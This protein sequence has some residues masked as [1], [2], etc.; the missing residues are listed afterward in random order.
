MGVSSPSR[1][2]ERAAELGY[3]ALALT[4]ENGVYGVVEAQKVGKL[5]GVKVLVGA[6]VQLRTDTGVYPLGLIAQN[7]GGYEVLCKLLTAIHADGEK[8]T[9]LPVLACPH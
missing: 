9:T 8:Q 3:T 7:R 4:D 5:F 2:V 6:T 1:L